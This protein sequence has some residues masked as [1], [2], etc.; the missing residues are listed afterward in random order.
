MRR[1]VAI[2]VFAL[3]FV[4][5]VA[6]AG[7]VLGE[8]LPPGPVQRL[9]ATYEVIDPPAQFD[10]VQ[11]VLDFAPGAFTPQHVHG[12]P[13]FVTVLEGEI[14]LRAVGGMEHK[15][16]TGEGWAETGEVHA[17]GNRGQS[18]A[19][20]MASFL[21]PP[22]APVT[23]PVQTGEAGT[24]PPGPSVVAQYRTPLASPPPMPYDVVHLLLDFPVGAFT[25]THVHGGP[26]IVTVVDGQ[27][28]SRA[29]GIEYTYQ[30]GESWLESGHFHAAGNRRSFK[31]S[32]AAGFL[33]PKGASLTSLEPR[34]RDGQGLS[35][36]STAVQ[37][38]FVGAWGDHAAMRWVEE[39]EAA[40][41]RAG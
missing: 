14:T 41:A 4:L 5:L 38:M 33:L 8:D 39:H 31:A 20:V 2:G 10:L 27:V 25:P 21:I 3:A 19:R 37:G 1:I 24:L 40:L 18:K 28:G 7:P 29:V 16:T 34:A 11:L 9:R 6:P 15:V 30:A 13:G 23:T 26:G 32:V 36:Q 35:T 22:G 17:G 12:G